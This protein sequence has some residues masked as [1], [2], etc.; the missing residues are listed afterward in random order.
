MDV[1]LRGRQGGLTLCLWV[2]AQLVVDEMDIDT[3]PLHEDGQ[4][5]GEKGPF[6]P[7]WDALM[8]DRDGRPLPHGEPVEAAPI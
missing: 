6:G 7:M 2:A 5:W 4:L 3:W 8:T 1:G